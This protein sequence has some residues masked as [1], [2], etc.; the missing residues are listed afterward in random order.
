MTGGQ[1]AAIIN[2]LHDLE[3]EG[4]INLHG[5]LARTY[6]HVVSAAEMKLASSASCAPTEVYFDIDQL[7]QAQ[8]RTVLRFVDVPQLIQEMFNDPRIPLEDWCLEIEAPVYEDEHGGAVYGPEAFQCD[9]F[10]ALVETRTQSTSV[11]IEIII[12]ADKS[13]TS[14]G[15]LHPAVLTLGNLSLRSRFSDAGLRTFALLPTIDVRTGAKLNPAE[16]ALR[17]Q[18]V[19]DALAIALSSANAS[20]DGVLLVLPGDTVPT[21]CELRLGEVIGDK[22]EDSALTATVGGHDPRSYALTH[23]R[24]LDAQ[25]E[26]QLPRP[27]LRGDVGSRSAT[28]EPRTAAT[29]LDR[30]ALCIQLAF[31]R[32]KG[33]AAKLAKTYGQN[34]Q[35]KVTI[36]SLCRLVPASLGGLTQLTSMDMMHVAD[37]GVT[38]K[39]WLLTEAVIARTFEKSGDLAS[40]QDVRWLLEKRLQTVP[41]MCDGTGTTLMRFVHG[42]WKSGSGISAACEW[43]SF[44]AQLPV[45]IL[46]DDRLIPDAQTRQRLATLHCAYSDIYQRLHSREW[47]DASDVARFD[48][49]LKELVVGFS[50][51][52]GVLD[53]PVDE[54]HT[55]SAAEVDFGNGLDIPKVMDLGSAAHGRKRSGALSGT[56]T[57]PFERTNKQLKKNCNATSRHHVEQGRRGVMLRTV[58]Q[59][60][61]AAPKRAEVGIEDAGAMESA[62]ADEDAGAVGG[63]DDDDVDDESADVSGPG[64]THRARRVATFGAADTFWQDVEAVLHAGVN[65]PAFSLQALLGLAGRAHAVCAS[66]LGNEASF[67]LPCRDVRV[68]YLPSGGGL[69]F[70][71]G[72]CVV[73]RDGRFAQL[74]I[75]VVSGGQRSALREVSFVVNLLAA[76]SRCSTFHPEA[77]ALRWFARAPEEPAGLALVPAGDI[78]CRVHVVPLHGRAGIIP[79]DDRDFFFHLPGLW[80]R[81]RQVVPRLTVFR[82]CPF[83][84][85]GRARQPPG[86]IA[87]AQVRCDKPECL[88]SFRF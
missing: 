56:T 7:E 73:L 42:P 15:T 39:L 86:A 27:Y 54:A 78:E 32:K 30:Q 87:R 14:I 85:G 43:A 10:K 29:E 80:C 13:G 75:P 18:V 25:C 9:H 4:L 83:C 22:Q 79:A 55:K 46:G 28:A 77:P 5:N 33:A 38:P 71:P 57:S 45:C 61:G 26:A 59:E 1:G 17:D 11:V 63:A 37:L 84:D 53:E 16:R 34:A 64:V 23:A 72:N 21:L 65:G 50:W 24:A 47:V 20:A 66:P 68:Q 36:N 40:H 82:K 48:A 69:I 76:P 60:H 19:M 8:Q 2:V 49:D 41:K 62:A 52:H 58:L 31:L 81:R 67:L 88:K 51:L 6:C 70:S 3:E 35:V 12:W 74:V 44:F